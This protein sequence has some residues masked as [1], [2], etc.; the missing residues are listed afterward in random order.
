MSKSKH[1]KKGFEGKRGLCVEVRNGNVEQ[2]IRLLTK[3]VKQEGLMR[4][5]RQRTFFEKPSVV[6]RRKAAEA[7]SRHRKALARNKDN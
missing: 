7:V 3:K 1:P 4:E 6:R 5:L 2:A